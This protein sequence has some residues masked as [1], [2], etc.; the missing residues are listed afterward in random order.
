MLKM[1]IGRAMGR[2]CAR[3]WA[4]S[5]SLMALA[6]PAHIAAK[7]PE[8]PDFLLTMGAEAGAGVIAE[9]VFGEL[10]LKLAAQKRL[11]SLLCDTGPCQTTLRIEL[12]APLRL[13]LR[14][15]D[16][17]DNELIRTQDWDQNADLL[18]ILRTLRYGD[19]TTPVAL[20]LGATGPQS[21]GHGTLVFNYFN[22]ISPDLYQLGLVARADQ[23]WGGLKLMADD[24][25]DP[26]L[27][28]ARAS[29][30]PATSLAIG[31]TFMAD[32]KAPTRLAEAPD[33]SLVVAPGQQPQIAQTSRAIWWGADL[34]WWTTL[35]P[36]IWSLYADLNWHTQR[37]QGAH[38][39]SQ[40][41]AALGPL[42]WRLRAELTLSWGGYIPRYVGPLYELDRLQSAGFNA[43]IPLPR[44]R[45]ATTL[46]QSARPGFF[47]DMELRI[48]PLEAALT[49]AASQ[50]GQDATTSTIFAMLHL[51]P[52]QD[53]WL[54]S[55]L[56][57]QGSWDVFGSGRALWLNEA[58][59]NLTSWLYAHGRFNRLWR[60]HP[61]GRFEGIPEAFLG[62]GVDVAL[63]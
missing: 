24:L 41:A 8:P 10:T 58:R 51:H 49:I 62:L 42:K 11:P 28:V 4:M 5:L 1:M 35:S 25:L 30:Y 47:A 54:A 21:I 55:T 45:L 31:A 50:Q 32:W 52:T 26:S 20:A 14:D 34:T 18:R 2:R 13:R 6:W 46:N 19:S 23:P 22:L 37:G 59:Y 53:L 56:A 16:P 63:E 9:D 39:G 7:A 43:P 15:D 40:I 38:L 29:F 33:G 57:H 12:I 44:A 27:T 36:L 61:E 60:L 17:Q 3:L 48:D